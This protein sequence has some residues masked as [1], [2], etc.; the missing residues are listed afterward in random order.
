[1]ILI[2]CVNCNQRTN[3]KETSLIKTQKC[4]Y[5]GYEY[6]SSVKYLKF[7]YTSL[8]KKNYK[9]NYL[10]NQV[11]NNN[12]LLSY[13]TQKDASL[14]LPYRKDVT[15][16]RLFIERSILHRK[17][18]ND[19]FKILDIGC[20]P[21]KLPG[22]LQFSNKLH[23]CKLYGIDPIDKRSFN[24]YR[25]VGTAEYMPFVND[26]FDAIIFA[27]SLDHL[28]S[29][30][31]T[32]FETYRV[33]KNNG[34]VLIWMSDRSRFLQKNIKELIA[35]LLFYLKNGYRQEKYYF[36]SKTHLYYIPDGAVDPFH[37][38]NETPDLIKKCFEKN[39]MELIDY[40]HNNINEVF[41][42]FK[43]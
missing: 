29:L 39:N 6:K 40:R 8:L 19:K 11:L 41:L 13:I 1:M 10:L 16:F 14:S 32:I 37:S 20:G 43:K 21:L 17:R 24:G 42:A 22:Y 18:V 25:V 27:T 28:C 12:A 30:E 4:L 34:L 23:G 36:T 26:Y 3:F 31:K 7:D 5:C 9:K 15:N 35:N 38:F 33:L 2:Q